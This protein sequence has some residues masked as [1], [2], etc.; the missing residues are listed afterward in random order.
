AAAWIELAAAP[1][2]H[3]AACLARALLHDPLGPAVRP[4]LQ[5]ALDAAGSDVP[6]RAQVRAHLARVCTLQGDRP[7]ARAWADAVVHDRAYPLTPREAAILGPRTRR[8]RAARPPAVPMGQAA[9]PITVRFFGAP[10]VYIGG[11]PLANA[12][13]THSKGRELLWYALA[14][15]SAGFTREEVCADLFPDMDAEAGGRALR[16]LLY[17]LR[18][19]L[20]A[21]CGVDTLRASADGRLRLRPEDMGPS[22]DVDTY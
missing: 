5:Q 15:G 9:A 10:M 2:G 13:W 14:H 16:N 22:W 7:G 4:A 3:P 6:L 21:H 18:K 19:R 20:R 17:E 11:Q 1:S 8:V 12:G